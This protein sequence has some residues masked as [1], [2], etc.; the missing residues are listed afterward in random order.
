MGSKI[1][2]QYYLG[3]QWD[4]RSNGKLYHGIRSDHG[5]NTAFHRKSFWNHGSN[6]GIHAHVWVKVTVNAEDINS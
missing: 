6:F 1:H 3:I 5:S 4:P 2:S